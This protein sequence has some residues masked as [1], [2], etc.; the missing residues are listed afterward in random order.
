MLYLYANNAS[1]I[2]IMYL[3]N[4]YN[5]HIITLYCDILPKSNLVN[6]ASESNEI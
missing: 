3:L 6:G 4:I 5:M 2:L 1:N